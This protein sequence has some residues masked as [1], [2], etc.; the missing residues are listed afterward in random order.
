MGTDQALINNRTFLVAFAK[1]LIERQ[2]YNSD[3][4]LFGE[5]KNRIGVVTMPP[6]VTFRSYEICL[7]GPG[8]CPTLWA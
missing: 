1:S 2:S 7:T 6:A 4:H 8:G 3:P 5:L